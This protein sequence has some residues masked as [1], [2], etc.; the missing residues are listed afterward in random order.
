[1]KLISPLLQ[2]HRLI[3]KMLHLLEL[4]MKKIEEGQLAYTIFVDIA[5][6]R[7]IIHWKYRKAATVL[8]ERTW[9]D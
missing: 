2:E 5:T 9:N 6:D 3:E 1:M 7:N 8:E 4:E